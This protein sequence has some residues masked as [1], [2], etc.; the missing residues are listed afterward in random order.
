MRT[1]VQEAKANQEAGKE[2][3]PNRNQALIIPTELREALAADEAAH[4]A[5]EQFTVGK[6]REYATYI[7]EAKQV[8]TKTKRLAKILPL[9]AAGKGL[10]DRY[11][12]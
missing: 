6:Q 3:T 7:D 2:I 10:N 12:S 9:I 8:A 4:R 1:Y 11:R 5:F